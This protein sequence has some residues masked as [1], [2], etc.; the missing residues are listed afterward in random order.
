MFKEITLALPRKQNW[1]GKGGVGRR[2]ITEKAS[3]LNDIPLH[4]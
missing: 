4:E 3:R 1:C 2:D